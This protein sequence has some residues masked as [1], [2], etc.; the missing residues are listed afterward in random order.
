MNHIIVLFLQRACAIVVMNAL[1]CYYF[2]SYNFPIDIKLK[3]K[4]IQQKKIFKI[5]FMEMMIHL[6]KKY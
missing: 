3:K 6:Q 2:S 4:K 5:D 1:I